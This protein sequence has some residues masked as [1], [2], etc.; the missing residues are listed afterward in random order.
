MAEQGVGLAF[1]WFPRIL[2]RRRVIQAGHYFVQ[3]KRIHETEFALDPEYPRRSPDVRELLG[4]AGGHLVQLCRPPDPL[5]PSG[6]VVGEAAAPEDIAAWAARRSD[7]G[8]CWPEPPNSLAHSWRGKARWH[9]VKAPLLFQWRRESC[10]S[11]EA[12]ARR[13]DNLSGNSAP[14]VRRYFP[15]QQSI[16]RMLP[17]RSHSKSL[18]P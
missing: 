12:P 14:P 8:W 4:S 7:A 15:C 10:S 1:C 6:I 3:G 17:P 18:R 5:P 13:R 2:A 11:A 16:P 9:G